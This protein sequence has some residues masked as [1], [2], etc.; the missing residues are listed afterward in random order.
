[1]SWIKIFF[2]IL[3][4]R[5]KACFWGGRDCPDTKKIWYRG[6]Q[7]QMAKLN[8]LFALANLN[9]ADRPCLSA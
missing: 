7:K 5:M 9:L 6:L 8:I 3:E 4:D 2:L 1:M